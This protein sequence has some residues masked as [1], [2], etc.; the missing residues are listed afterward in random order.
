MSGLVVLL[1]ALVICGPVALIWAII[2]TRRINIL[3]MK[4]D[5]LNRRH[6]AQESA[7]AS[8]SPGPAPSLS[9]DPDP[10]ELVPAMTLP[11]MKEKGDVPSMRE[12]GDV[13][14]VPEQKT[15]AED[16]EGKSSFERFIGMRALNWVGVITILFG[17]A[18]ALKVAYTRGWLG[19]WGLSL[20][21]YSLGV[22]FVGA[23]HVLRRRG[24]GLAAEGLSALGFGVLFAASYC[25][26]HLFEIVSDETAFSFMVVTT[27][28]GGLLSARYRS[29]VLAGLTFLGGY[30]T[31][32]L[33][34]TGE[35]HGGFLV[36]Y[37]ALLG[38]AAGAFTYARRWIFVKLLS[39]VA[40]WSIFLGWYVTF[41]GDRTAVALAGTVIFF[42]LNTLAPVLPL[43]VGKARSDAGD[44][45][46]IVGNAIFCL[47]FLY[48]ILAGHAQVARSF[49]IYGLSL[50]FLLQ[51]LAFRRRGLEQSMLGLA[52]LI[53]A[54]GF[55]TV[56]VP[57]NLGQL[58]TAVTWAAEG[59]LLLAFGFG[60]RKTPLLVGSVVSLV[61]SLVE[62]L[63]GLPLHEEVFVPVFNGAFCAWI[64]LAA[65]CGLCAAWWGGKAFSR[66]E[67]YP[68]P[69]VKRFFSLLLA[70]AAG[71]LVCFSSAAE[72]FAH[73]GL[74]CDL[75][76]RKAMPWIWIVGATVSVLYSLLASRLR[77]AP[78]SI[79]GIALYAVT[80]VSLV[81]TVFSYHE[82]EFTLFLNPCL[83]CGIS[84][85]VA[86]LVH[87]GLQ[88]RMKGKNSG[89]FALTFTVFAGAVIW[90]VVANEVLSCCRNQP[91]LSETDSLPYIWLIGIVPALLLALTAARRRGRGEGESRSFARAGIGFLAFDLVTF[92][93]T[94][95]LYHQGAFTPLCNASF[96]CGLALAFSFAG[97]ALL[98]PGLAGAGTVPFVWGAF[99]IVVFQLFSV[100][101]YQ[102]FA[103]HPG[104]GAEGR[105]W[106]LASLSVLWAFFGAGLLVAGVL[107][108]VASLRFTAL[109][110]FG[111]TLGKVFLLDTSSLEPIYR[112]L[113]FLTLG[114]VLMAG[115]FAYSKFL[116]GRDDEGS[117]ES[118]LRGRPTRLTMTGGKR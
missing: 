113:G 73:T 54:V 68:A 18:S 56:A 10:K 45:I 69:G 81:V 61:L 53:L 39:F 66:S 65:A 80:L 1:I 44:V 112:I 43:L 71:L 55:F 48:D 84:F 109:A 38:C 76:W 83:F 8:L 29:Q 103:F 27:V 4:Q 74:N 79:A 72:I 22:L 14:G 104:L 98:L 106:A 99:I 26:R 34:A 12:K 6:P 89:F 70:V 116:R 111:L 96:L 115:S 75:P 101:T 23:G 63:R 105:L 92:A 90:I 15:P 86:G 107:K 13:D 62:L 88:G 52:S 2:L 24:F 28:G 77:Q 95:F 7:A 100:E 46:A 5:L 36:C 93:T 94:C 117:R 37:L 58:A 35:D 110:L 41:G 78:L 17:V 19:D 33:L 50:F 57:I 67:A 82:T 25:A 114:G 40:S 97:A 42:F 32:V 118:A 60:S 47:F 59:V 9:P 30:L 91:S 31:P 51:Y 64:V 3:E 49:A 21:V 102:Y 108:R 11:S 85:A 20:L 16:C 87:A